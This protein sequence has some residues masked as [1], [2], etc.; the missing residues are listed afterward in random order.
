MVPRVTMLD[1]VTAVAECA[2]SDAEV[3]ATVVHL[4]N[5]GKVRLAGSLRGARF[6]VRAL[7]RVPAVAA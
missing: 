3:V 2:Q 7:P 5:T 4:I 6:D 1:L